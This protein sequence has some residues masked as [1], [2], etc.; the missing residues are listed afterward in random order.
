[1]HIYVCV[2]IYIYTY[3]YIRIDIYIALQTRS[4]LEATRKPKLL[5]YNFLKKWS[6]F[7][8][9]WSFK[10]YTTVYT[11]RYSRYPLLSFVFLSYPSS[12]TVHY[13][14]GWTLDFDDFSTT[15][16]IADR[17]ISEKD[18]S[19]AKA[20][21]MEAFSAFSAASFFSYQLFQP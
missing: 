20:A 15:D 8:A 13:L 7:V 16:N 21:C 4:S 5:Y 18:R 19:D 9:L 3:I 1:M 2:C 17:D 10:V 14:H 11:K 12:L 6:C